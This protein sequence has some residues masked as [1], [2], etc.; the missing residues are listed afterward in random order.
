MYSQNIIARR[1]HRLNKDLG[2]DLNAKRLPRDVSIETAARLQKL[3]FNERGEPGPDGWLSRPLDT[4]E[5]AFTESERLLCKADFEYYATRY[6]QIGIDTGTTGE[7]E[8]IGP[9]K[10][11]ESQV[12]LLKALGKREEEVHAEFA[13]YGT[14]EGIR[15]IAHKTRQQY[16]TAI[17]R[18]LT[19][20]RMLFWPGTR[21]LAAALNPKG[22]GELYKRDKV[23]LD[24][25]PFWMKPEVYPDVKD[26]EL[27]FKHPLN[28]RLLYQA[29][30]EKTG[31]AVGT[32]QDVSHLTEVPL[33]QFPAYNIGFSLMAA[34]P[35][36]RA[37]LHLQEGT[38][39]GGFGYWKEISE[40]VR[41]KEV[42]WESWC[43][44]FIPWYFN[45]R[46]NVK[47]VP[48][49]WTPKKHTLEHA[50]LIERTSS[51]WNDGVT[52]RPSK[53]Q[54][55]WWET[56]REI[57]SRNNSLGAFLATYPGTP[58]QSFTNWSRGA[59]PVELIEEMELDERT[60]NYYSIEVVN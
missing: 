20:H 55:Y 10:F 2:L 28:S 30:N 6:H 8:T 5:L 38:S 14:T 36:S 45:S 34:I 60:A 48:F 18:M 43:Y 56:E 19:I 54:L 3:R 25:L 29:E 57:Y 50:A 9:V 51:E 42:G 24:N 44:V 17:C 27:G 12:R 16:Y 59:L 1:I 53:E 37:T 31:L 15:V 7:E 47:I 33:W 26:E 13:K 52:T 40:S 4:K 32:T 58:E 21:A 22:V 35:K 23:A 11:Q 39:S 41:N 46:K 49:G